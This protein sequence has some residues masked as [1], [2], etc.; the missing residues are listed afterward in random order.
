MQYVGETENPL[1]LRMNGHRSD[2]YHRLP[3]KPVAKHFFN[4]PDHTF[5]D[6]TIMII[7]RLHSANSMQQKYRESY[8]VYILW[9]LTPDGLNLELSAIS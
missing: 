9:T 3:D 5:E 2:Y 6:A 8:W 4:T 7:K 1:H